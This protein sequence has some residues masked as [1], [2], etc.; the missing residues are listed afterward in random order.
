MLDLHDRVEFMADDGA[1][2]YVISGD[3]GWLRHVYA[4]Y[5]FLSRQLERT[6]A[7]EEYRASIPALRCGEHG[8]LEGPEGVADAAPEDLA[9]ACDAL[10][11]FDFP[12]TLCGL[13]QG[14]A[15]VGVFMWAIKQGE[16]NQ[17]LRIQRSPFPSR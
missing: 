11:E 4:T 15:Q 16:D 1:L 8:A 12:Y 13:V 5:Q 10:F 2:S 6:V 3:S 9:D 14:L 7:G 17:N